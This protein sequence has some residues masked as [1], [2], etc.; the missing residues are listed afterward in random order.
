MGWRERRVRG[1]SEGEMGG[2]EIK[3][4]DDSDSG[5]TAR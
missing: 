5:E 4:R 2:E 1:R 3:A